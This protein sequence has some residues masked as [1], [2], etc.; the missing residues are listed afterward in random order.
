MNLQEMAAALPVKGL[1]AKLHQQEIQ[2]KQLE[3]EN[4]WLREQLANLMVKGDRH[5]Q[6]ISSRR[7]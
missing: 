7:E 2:I 4:Q 6:K 1:R 5:S 3:E